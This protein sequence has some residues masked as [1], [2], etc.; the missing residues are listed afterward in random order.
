LLINCQSS[1]DGSQT[2]SAAEVESPDCNRD[3][4]SALNPR[5]RAVS[6]TSSV[7]SDTQ[8][9]ATKNHGR[10]LSL[11]C[12]QHL[13]VKGFTFNYIRQ[14]IQKKA[15]D[16][17]KKQEDYRSGN[18]GK[19]ILAS[20]NSHI[21]ELSEVATQACEKANGVGG[22]EDVVALDQKGLGHRG[23][24][25]RVAHHASLGNT[26]MLMGKSVEAKAAV[27]HMPRG[28]PRK[29]PPVS[30]SLSNQSTSVRVKYHLQ[31]NGNTNSVLGRKCGRPRITVTGGSS[32]ID[33]HMSVAK[34]SG[35]VKD[36]HP[37][38]SGTEED[39]KTDECEKT[40]E[41][42]SGS[43]DAETVVRRRGR[44]R[45]QTAAGTSLRDRKPLV[46]SDCGVNE[47]CETT[48]AVA[49]RCRRP[50]KRFLDN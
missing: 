15:A 40:S 27:V 12:G 39:G 30:A 3:H 18:I 13:L 26:S 4:L 34:R 14:K 24:K 48:A 45:K 31:S 41:V 33:R 1:C 29:R 6:I 7:V 50:C 25:T 8:P 46:M 38:E 28:R 49:R 22:S 16:C 21:Q 23:R 2:Q 44:P 17:I 32:L 47:H 9:P 37:C 20:C 35:E 10:P 5:G 19:E 42:C 43:T 36:E 11:H